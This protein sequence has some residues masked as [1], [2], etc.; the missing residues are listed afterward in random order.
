MLIFQFVTFCCYIFYWF[1]YITY[2]LFLLVHRFRDRIHHDS[3]GGTTRLAC[4][5]H[6]HKR[7][8]TASWTILCTP[9]PRPSCHDRLQQHLHTTHSIHGAVREEEQ[10][11]ITT[12]LLVH[13]QG[14]AFQGR[15]RRCHGLH[16]LLNEHSD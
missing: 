4:T 12:I 10:L 13:D 16:V 8:R 9:L 5:L 1:T 7:L 3:G 2:L 15:R 14:D 6:I 11:V